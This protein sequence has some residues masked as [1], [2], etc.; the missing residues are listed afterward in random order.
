MPFGSSTV[1][2]TWLPSTTTGDWITYGN[3]T[4]TLS[5][6]ATAGRYNPVTW[7]TSIGTITV[8]QL[9][10]WVVTTYD[11]DHW[12]LT[13]EGR[14]EE[15]A[16]VE[17][18]RVARQAEEARQEERRQA[19]AV[20]NDRALELLMSVLDEVQAEAYRQNRTFEVIGSHGGLY[21]IRPGIMANV[22]ALDPVTREFIGRLCAHPQEWD[23]RGILPDPDLALGQLLDLTS[24]EPGFVRDANVHGG[25]R[26]E[27]AQLAAA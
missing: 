18:R 24:D 8:N 16:R 12:G 14:A 11:P 22:D 23:G 7:S 19:R 27:V 15:A 6:S 26:P 17:T 25:R 9:T 20:V 13:E 1:P 2:V 5:T 10:P 21:R 3:S 4:I